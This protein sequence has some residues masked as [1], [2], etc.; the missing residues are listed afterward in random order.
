MKDKG[1]S[2]KERRARIEN[3]VADARSGL[4]IPTISRKYGMSTNTVNGLCYKAG[5][6]M[7]GKRGSKTLYRKPNMTID[8]FVS[9][10]TSKCQKSESGCLIWGGFTLEGFPC[11]VFNGCN[12]ASRTVCEWKLGRKLTRFERVHQTC[13]ERRCLNPEHLFANEFLDGDENYRKSGMNEAETVAW[14]LSKCETNENGCLLWTRWKTK[15]YPFIKFNGKTQPLHRLVYEHSTGKKIPSDMLVCHKCDTPRCVNID[16]LF[17]GTSA[18]NAA[19][20]VSKNRQARNKGEKNG[21]S[22]LKSKDVIEIRNLL[23][24]GTMTYARIAS[25]YSVSSALIR[26]IKVRKLW[27]H[28]P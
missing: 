6:S 19:D 12:R 15:K 13:K 26:A 1:M 3:I 28:L 10:I 4:D 11:V 23:K 22:K 21:Y 24:S 14:A 18:D 7:A 17:L 25:L 27:K 20:M 2:F 9:W 8:E 5:L 16:H